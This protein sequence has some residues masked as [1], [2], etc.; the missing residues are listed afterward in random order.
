[1]PHP[2][3]MAGSSCGAAFSADLVLA[4]GRTSSLLQ[5]G[6]R[7]RTRRLDWPANLFMLVDASAGFAL[8]ISP[9]QVRN[10]R[11]LLPEHDFV[12]L[13]LGPPR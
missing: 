11:G 7:R 1:M 5:P 3:P 9:G 4:I 12:S 2:V 8:I 10:K 13:S 6:S